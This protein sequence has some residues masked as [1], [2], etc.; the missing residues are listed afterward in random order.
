M[1][2]LAFSYG[3]A[4]FR[5][6]YCFADFNFIHNIFA[7]LLALKLLIL[8][9]NYRLAKFNFWL[10]FCYIKRYLLLPILYKLANFSV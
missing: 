8:A 7:D 2:I 6:T 9:F 10:Q 5:F 4:T 3:F 1:L